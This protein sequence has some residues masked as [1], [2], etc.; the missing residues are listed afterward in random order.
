[1][2]LPSYDF[3]N[4]EAGDTVKIE[5]LFKSENTEESISLDNQTKKIKVSASNA[6]KLGIHEF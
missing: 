4:K 5:L 1:M 2:I 3:F 6:T